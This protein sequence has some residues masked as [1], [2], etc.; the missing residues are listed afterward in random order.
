M[1]SYDRP[2][3]IGQPQYSE[4]VTLEAVSMLFDK[5]LTETPYAVLIFCSDYSTQQLDF[6]DDFL[7]NIDVKV[8]GGIFPSIVYDGQVL[9][10]GIVVV[11]V[12]IPVD[13]HLYSELCDASERYFEFD[14]NLANCQS[15]LVLTDG[16]ARNIDWA[17]NQIF[18][19]VGQTSSVFGGGAGSL[20]FEQK[21]C[22]FTNQGLKMDA[23][24]VM[25]MQHNWD[26]AIGHGWE[27]LEGPFLANQVDDNRIIQLNFEPASH[28]YKS[29]VEKH[30]GRLFQDNE[31]FELAKT[32]PFGLERL[33]DDI[34]VRDPVTIENDSLVCVGKVPE[35]TMLYILKGE[36]DKL[37]SA[38]VLAVKN[39]VK[40]NTPVTGLL[41]DCISRKLFLQDEFDHELGGMSAALGVD[42]TLIGAL[43]LG[44][45]ASGMSGTIHFHN[46]TAVMAVSQVC[47]SEYK[48]H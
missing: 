32:Y 48:P 28:L 39:T 18:Q 43:V 37:I 19:C 7:K 10:Q 33:D 46:K 29:V 6:F 11:P 1:H 27:V 16:L 17:L 47:T 41:F 45:I 26:L 5:A 24:L 44:E 15:L 31:F 4:E 36:N 35:N 3:P 25:V 42:G 9:E 22:L 40:Q 13:I 12:L 14:F 2:L 34:L 21:P 30:D 8:C 23:M 20:N 38:A